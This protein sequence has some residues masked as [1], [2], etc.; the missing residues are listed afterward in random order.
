MR[1]VVR[2]KFSGRVGVVARHLEDGRTQRHLGRATDINNILA[3]YRK[4]GVIEHV[5]RTQE[6]YGDFTMLADFAGNLDMTAKAQQ[7]FEALP[8]SLRNQFGNSIP[9]FYAFV[10]NPENKEQLRKWGMLKAAPDEPAAV[11]AAAKPAEPAPQATKSG[12]IKK[13]KV[14]QPESTDGEE[15]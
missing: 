7:A 13:S 1:R 10:S 2:S 5:K 8:A 14:I 15:A 3:K 12:A 6:R 11:P 9:D 4:T